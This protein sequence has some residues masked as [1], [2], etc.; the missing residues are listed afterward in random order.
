MH[1]FFKA[2]VQN[3]YKHGDTD[4]F[5][6]PIENRV[7]HDCIDQ[8]SSLLVDAFGRFDDFFAQNPPDDIR[9]PVPVHH[10]GFRWATQL[11]PFW[12]TF[13]LGCVISIAEY[14]E[15]A[16]LP[17]T[18]VFSYRLDK[19]AYATGDLF[20]RDIS[21][22]DFMRRS[23]ELSADYA[24]VVVCDISDCYARISHHKLDNALRMVGSPDPVRHAILRYLG[25]LTGTRSSGLPIGGP[26]ARI[27][28]ELALNNSD[29][30]LS[31]SGISFVRYADDYHIFCDNRKE[32]YERL[33]TIS[34]ALD[35]EGLSLQRSKTRILSRAE[36]AQINKNILGTEETINSPVHRLMSLGLRY[37][38]YSAR[39]AE[40]YEAL[41]RELTQIDIVGL[42]N[43][44]LAKTRVH[45]A[46]TK[47]IIAAL[48][49]IDEAARFGAVASMLNS[50]DVLYPIAANV[51][52]AISDLFPS[53][54]TEQQDEVCARLRDLYN[55]GHEV[56]G[57]PIHVAFSIRIIGQRNTAENQS[58]LHRC[59][60]TEH[61]PLVRRDI[62]VVFAN[63][64]NFAWLSIFKARFGN[65][66]G[67]E[68]R[69]LIL[70]SYS[71]LDEGRHWRDHVKSRFDPVDVL[72]RDWRA[73][74][75]TQAPLLPL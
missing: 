22:L 15:H 32:A 70:A 26:A 21:W 61:S 14:I 31:D 74:R 3:V 10:V 35:N 33:V 62:I 28:A 34:T 73:A 68:R 58:F 39:A 27:L 46:A 37:D 38:P 49:L 7:F 64:H 29:R 53:L 50:I 25:F 18:V 17:H 67:W 11:D 20:R 65:V 60:E 55:G 72:V 12:N 51:L 57:L 69:A 44:Q 2:A 13:F 36:F 6:F 30:I 71:M 23:E 47:K 43:E 16:R 48:A 19:G 66:S 54:T 41:R 24:F 56:M 5:P 63:W 4:I 1:Q 59:F 40:H 75:A 45:I 52:I 42:L 8:L 9:S